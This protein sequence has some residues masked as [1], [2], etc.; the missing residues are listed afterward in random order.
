MDSTTGLDWR[1]R[2]LDAEATV[3]RVRTLADELGVPTG[4]N[5]WKRQAA[6]LIRAALAVPS[7]AEEVDDDEP[8]LPLDEHI[9]NGL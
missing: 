2:A 5:G 9:R 6:K 1:R 7:P 3:E 4:M 8:N